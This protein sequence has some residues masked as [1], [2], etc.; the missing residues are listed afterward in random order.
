MPGYVLT[1]KVKPP[2]GHEGIVQVFGDPVAGSQ[3]LTRLDLWEISRM[4]KEK[5]AKPFPYAFGPPVTRITAHRLLAASV[6]DLLNLTYDLCNGRFEED[7]WSYGGCYVFR[8]KK[9]G[10]KLS[11]H[12]WGIAVDLG[13]KRNPMGAAWCSKTGLPKHVIELWCDAGWQ[14]GGFWSVPDP[15]H[16]QYA[17]LY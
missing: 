4:L 12:A 1:P 15:M 11:T 16:F 3:N 7:R 6:R 2:K 9:N 5:L 10:R 8:P 14:W 17:K 13:P